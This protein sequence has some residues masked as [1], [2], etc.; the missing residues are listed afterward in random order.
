MVVIYINGKYDDG[1]RRDIKVIAGND[2]S[3][4]IYVIHNNF[5]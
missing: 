4:I 3:T 1:G 5:N 2:T